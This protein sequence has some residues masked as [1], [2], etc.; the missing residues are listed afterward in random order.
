[1]KEFDSIVIGSGAGGLASALCLARAGQKVLVLEQHEVPGGW[2]HSFTLNGQRFSPG[3]H[4]IGRL[5]NGQSTNVLYKGLGVSEDLTFFRMNKSG[6]DHCLIGD[7]KFDYPAGIENLKSKLIK[8]FPEEK[9]NIIK[10]LQLIQKVNYELSLIPKLKGIWQNL[11]VPFRT[12]HFG[13]YAL[14]SLKRVINWHI[15]DARLKA[16][17]NAQCGDHGL[18]PAKASFPVHCSVMHHYFDGGFYPLGGGGGIVKAMTNKIKSYGGS[19]KTQQKVKRILLENNKAYGVEMQNNEKFIAKNIISNAD[20]STTYLELIGRKNCSKKLLKKLDKTAYS[21]TSLILFLT[22]DIDVTKY[23]IDS[24]NI[25]KYKDEDID[26]HF[27]TLTKGNI[28]EG[29]EFPAIF[30]SCT[31]LKDPASFNGRYHNFE[32]VTYVDFDSFKEFKGKS[33]YQSSKYE[34]FKKRIIEKFLNSVEK[35]IPTANEHIVQVELGTPKT[36][37]YY[38]N[39]TRGN[40][41]GTEKSLWHLGPFIFK[42]KTE[43]EN[44]FLCGASTLSHGVTG[45]TYSGVEAAAAILNCHSDTL[46]AN[47]NS[48]EINIFDAEDPGSWSDYIHKK[49]EDKIRSFK[50]IKPAK[51]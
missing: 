48:K 29:D 49:R 27:E 40:V 24:G 19:I 16:I 41:Y 42:N 44:L 36:N 30:M 13:K 14:F 46:L 45:A 26:L 3:V 23:G 20:P 32:V 39:S 38:I 6:F 5:D 8:D 18:S 15:K 50:A 33:D 17:L 7:K 21:V 25:W 47:E 9:K 1:M 35:I 22:L 4:Y 43:I 2:S 10:Y 31:T 11:T 12:K 37:Q 51:N 34:N 28:L